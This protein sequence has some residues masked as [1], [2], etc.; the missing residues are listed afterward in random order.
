MFAGIIIYRIWIIRVEYL[1]TAAIYAE[2]YENIPDVFIWI[3][4]AK[5][6]ILCFFY[7]NPLIYTI[8]IRWLR[9]IDEMSAELV[10]DSL[11]M[12]GLSDILL[13]ILG[14]IIIK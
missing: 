7:C 9:S 14:N 4:W 5:Y 10:L 2:N 12:E 13:F 11:F 8:F 3:N 6:Y 1:A